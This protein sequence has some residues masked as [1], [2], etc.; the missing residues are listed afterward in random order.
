MSSSTSDLASFKTGRDLARDIADVEGLLAA[1]E[2]WQIDLRRFKV[3][4][5]HVSDDDRSGWGVVEKTERRA[6]YGPGHARV[7]YEI[8]D[9]TYR[10]RYH[11]VH[12]GG[13]WLVDD[14]AVQSVTPLVAPGPTL[15]VQQAAKGVLPA[16]MHVEADSHSQTAVGTGFVIQSSATA[17][18]IITNDHVVNGASTV[19]L[20][21]W[22]TASHA[23]APTIPWV[24]SQVRED[25]AD[26]LA[27]IKIDQG[28]LPVAAWGN[29]DALQ[30]A[31][32]VVA[33][34]YAENLSG[35]PSVTNGIVSSVLR[36]TPGS[37]NGPT[38]IQHSAPINP[39]NSGGPLADMSGHV[40]GIN[41]LT[42]DNTQGLFFAIPSS[43]AARV[44][45][46][47]IGSNG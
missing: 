30:L 9:A 29:S 33:I 18:Y 12:E 28:N 6:L 31:D 16:V 20:Q 7:P 44:A 34:G 45:A 15:T 14:V 22:S 40:V 27:V 36:T 35:A 3:L 10:L 26:D 37:P 23:Y 24:A 38:Y 19:K 42:L 17:S 4:S 39:G 11:L 21:R 25:P 2:H 1:D 32:D 41:T 13:R 43:R 8:S 5:V 46:G 47:F